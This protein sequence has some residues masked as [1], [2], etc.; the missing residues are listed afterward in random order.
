MRKTKNKWKTDKCG[1]C[2]EKHFNYTGKLDKNNIEYVICGRTNKRI[3][4]DGLGKE[5]NTFAFPTL[6]IKEN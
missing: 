4:V 1:R 2:G 3:N 6:W 5:G